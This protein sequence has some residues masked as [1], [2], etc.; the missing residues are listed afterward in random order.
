M[1]NIF[2]QKIELHDTNITTNTLNIGNHIKNVSNPHKVTKNQIGLNNV[3]NTADNAKNV[4]SASKWTT[5]R[6]LTIGSAGKAVDG[7][8]NV[9]WSL[10]E[11]GAADR[12]HTH[13]KD[14]LELD[15][16]YILNLVINTIYPIGTILFTYTNNNPGTY[17]P[18]TTWVLASQGKYIR[19]VN[20]SDNNLNTVKTGGSKTLSLAHTHTTAGVA[21]TVAQMPAHNHGSKSLTGAISNFLVQSDDYPGY[22]SGIASIADVDDTAFSVYA[23]YGYIASERNKININATHTHT[24]QGSGSAHSH[25]NTGSALSTVNIE[26]EYQTLYCW[27]RSK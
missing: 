17:L 27:R 7:T 8:K 20:T 15:D 3:D 14:E 5:K 18:D 6:T 4:L 12:A 10:E 9:T 1:I 11:I 2:S 13:T 22:A 16:A 26:P 25:G 21:L 23:K 24:T 19:G